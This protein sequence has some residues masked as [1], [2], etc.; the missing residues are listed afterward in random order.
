M[1]DFAVKTVKFDHQH[2]ANCEISE[3]SCKKGVNDSTF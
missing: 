1:F 3:V 2:R